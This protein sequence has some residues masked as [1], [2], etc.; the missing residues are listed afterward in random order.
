MKVMNA[1]GFSDTADIRRP[2]TIEIPSRS[3]TIAGYGNM[4]RYQNRET[5]KVAV[6]NVF[7]S[8]D[9]KPH[10][11]SP[12][13]SRWSNVQTSSNETWGEALSLKKQKPVQQPRCTQ[14][15]KVFSFIKNVL[16]FIKTSK[17]F[18]MLI[19]IKRNQIIKR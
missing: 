11:E 10:K 2:S 13:C 7:R 1:E 15:T 3:I 18:K 8:E 5:V 9:S 6:H 12:Q 19:H 17:S 4:K 14:K 16:S